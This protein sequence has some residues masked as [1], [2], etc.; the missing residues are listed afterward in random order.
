MISNA[1]RFGLP[2][3]DCGCAEGGTINPSTFAGHDL[4]VL[5]LPADAASA[6]RELGDYAA[7][8]DELVDSDAWLLAFGAAPSGHGLKVYGDP[9]QRAWS[10]FRQLIEAPQTLMRDSGATFFFTR[11]GNLHRYWSG[12]GHLAEVLDELRTRQ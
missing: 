7:A 2:D 6:S 12:P 8:C 10:A 1:L 3:F 4:I 11:G 5:F 9:D